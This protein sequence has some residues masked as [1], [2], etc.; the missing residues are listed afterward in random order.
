MRGDISKISQIIGLRD[1]ERALLKNYH[2]MSS[3]LAGTRQV[4]NSIR[5][6]V[7]SS[8]IFYGAP[9]FMTFTPSERHSGLAIRLSRGRA[10]DPAF[11]GA[12]QVV[13]PWIGRD[14]PSLCPQAEDD[15]EEET[16]EVDLP[17]YDVRR[18]ITSRDPLC[19][20]HAFQVMIRV[21]LPGIFGFRMCPDCPHC[22]KG[23]DPCMDSFGSNATPTGG[24]AGRCDGMVGAVESQKADGVPHV[25]LFCT[26]KW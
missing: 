20:V 17:E 18:V 12:A 15:A 7:F 5:H 21:V 23:E 3:R 16:A 13:K 19:C 11:T 26:S 2:F 4:R 14:S 24:S 25:H 1:T 22:A 6:I 9:V 8:R 10:N